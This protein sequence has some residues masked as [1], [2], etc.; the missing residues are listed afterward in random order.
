[1]KDVAVTVYMDLLKNCWLTINCAVKGRLTSL[2]QILLQI[3]I[4]RNKGA[5]TVR[6][7]GPR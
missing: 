1:M 2:N 3:F 5:N 4:V 6:D 7:I